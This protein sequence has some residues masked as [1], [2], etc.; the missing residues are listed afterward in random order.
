MERIRGVP[1]SLDSRRRFNA[2]PGISEERE[3]R[4]RERERERQQ[5]E[6][7]MECGARSVG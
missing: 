6:G 7:G 5:G 2:S 4:A 1:S 3:R